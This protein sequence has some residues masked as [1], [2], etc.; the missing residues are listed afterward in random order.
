MKPAAYKRFAELCGLNLRPAQHVFARVAF[1]AVDPA[2]LNAGDRERA[3]A[4]FGNV[5]RV[6]AS[7]RSVIVQLKGRDVGGTRMAAY[8]CLQLGLTHPL[9]GLDPTEVPYVLFGGPKLRL[10]RIGLR[11]ALQAAKRLAARG[12]VR[13][14]EETADGF[15]VVRHDGRR[16]RFEC[17]A[18]A[19]G[20]DTARGVTVIA[21]LLD[22]AAFYLDEATGVVNDRTIFN[23]IIPRLLAGG[24]ILIVSSPWAQT[25]LLAEEFRTNHGQPTT[26]LA[27]HCPTLVMRDEPDICE[28]VAREWQRDAANARRELGAEFLT[29]G[30]NALLDG[31]AVTRSKDEARPLVVLAAGRRRSTA[32]DLGFR[33]NSSA[34]ST[35]A[36]EKPGHYILCESV[37]L[38]PQPNAPLKPSEVSAT[39]IEHCRKHGTTAVLADKHYVDTL[40][41]DMARARIGVYLLPDGALGKEQQFTAFR[42][43]LHEGRIKIPNLP[44]LIQQMREV[45]ARPTAGGGLSISSPVHRDGS[46][47]DILSSLVGA[48]WALEQARRYPPRPRIDYGRAMA[49]L[50]GESDKYDRGEGSVYAAFHHEE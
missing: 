6:P 13:I 2:D 42:D 3:G 12:N 10:A 24:Q 9:E 1:D 27:A 29:I 43:V 45:T 46:H 47:G 11:F 15:T 16:I 22:E 20:G 44:R 40:K 36:E 33:A 8:R 49:A 38:R 34:I 37:E 32:C 39:F 26:A 23:A 31:A 41:E 35:V 19:R 21:V 50:T 48:V 30:T 17:F 5:D 7:A 25:G 28:M 4:M 14:E 18:A